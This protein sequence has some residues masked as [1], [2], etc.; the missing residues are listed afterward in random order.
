[1]FH[2]RTWAHCIQLTM[3]AVP[4][5]L[6]LCKSPHHLKTPSHCFLG[7]LGLGR[8]A[9]NSLQTG[10]AEVFLQHGPILHDTL[11]G[12]ENQSRM[13]R[14]NSKGLAGGDGSHEK[15]GPAVTIDR[16]EI[17]CNA[18]QHTF[19][20]SLQPSYSQLF[21]DRCSAAMRCTNVGAEAASFRRLD[22]AA[23]TSACRSAMLACL[24][25]FVRPVPSLRAHLLVVAVPYSPQ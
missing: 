23:S 12:P 17:S 16:K 13:H 11:S 1:M 20:P 21:D 5:F 24:W 9:E 19:W 2:T 4:C 25:D 3:S 10:V 7:D 6:F 8:N 22:T 14:C 18:H 15:G